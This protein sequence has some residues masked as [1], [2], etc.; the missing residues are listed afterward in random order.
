[1][2]WCKDANYLGQVIKQQYQNNNITRVVSLTR[3]DFL[4]KKNVAFPIILHHQP[5]DAEFM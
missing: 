2:V 3:E 1:M 4:V 5:T